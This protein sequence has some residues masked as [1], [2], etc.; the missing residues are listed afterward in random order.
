MEKAIQLPWCGL[1]HYWTPRGYVSQSLVPQ[2]GPEVP[3]HRSWTRGERG[4]VMFE[5]GC[6]ARLRGFSTRYS[7]SRHPGYVILVLGGGY[8]LYDSWCAEERLQHAYVGVS[9]TDFLL[10]WVKIAHSRE[11]HLILSSSSFDPS[12]SSI[13]TRV[14]ACH[15]SP[16]FRHAL[17]IRVLAR[18]CRLVP[19]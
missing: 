15:S 3:A 18:R 14:L 11:S 7:C 1:L 10:R 16:R 6:R 12:S 4:E 2:E 5:S 9:A 17:S 8:G 13:D 19:R